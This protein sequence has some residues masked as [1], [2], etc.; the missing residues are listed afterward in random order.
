MV[1]DRA[2][3]DLAL[4]RAA[5]WCGVLVLTGVDRDPDVIPEEWRPDVVI[6]SVAD[7]PALLAAAG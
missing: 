4:A 7:L 1:G 5:G 3:T 2:A 6:D